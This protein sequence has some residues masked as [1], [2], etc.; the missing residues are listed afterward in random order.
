MNAVPASN[1]TLFAFAPSGESP[2]PASLLVPVPEDAPEA[3]ALF[4]RQ[5]AECLVAEMPADFSSDT[6]EEPVAADAESTAQPEAPAQPEAAAAATLSL[7]WQAI[8]PPPPP[9]VTPPPAE[10][11][12]ETPAPAIDPASL[13][14]TL[15]HEYPKARAPRETSVAVHATNPPPDDRAPVPQ[16]QTK[17][18]P[19]RSPALSSEPSASLQPEAS[20]A[21]ARLERAPVPSVPSV[22]SVPLAPP[23]KPAPAPEPVDSPEPFDSAEPAPARM[24]LPTPASR[25][26]PPVVP[27]AD[28]IGNAVPLSPTADLPPTGHP[29]ESPEASPSDGRF[30]MPPAPVLQELPV[31]SGP[32]TIETHSPGRNLPPTPS[33]SAETTLPFA[34]VAPPPGNRPATVAPN[35]TKPIESQT[36]PNYP[37]TPI[38]TDT[39][40]GTPSANHLA[41]SARKT[42]AEFEPERKSVRPHLDSAITLAP[43]ASPEPLPELHAPT[44]VAAADPSVR[45]ESVEKLQALL[46]REVRLFRQSEAESLQVVVEPASDLR[47]L[48]RVEL[49]DGRV[50]AELRCEQGDTVWLESHWPELQA[51]LSHQGVEL[52]DWADTTRAPRDSFA[53]TGSQSGQQRRSPESEFEPRPEMADAREPRAPART[54]VRTGRGL[55]ELWA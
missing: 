43:T 29:A 35:S 1:S 41:M 37:A 51:T 24:T 7:A 55:L 19:V 45:V 22:S 42:Y 52:R 40:S 48:L 46:V 44:K 49:R 54:P 30:K 27:P 15:V 13:R 28:K 3:A 16:T 47:L 23:A 18:K 32:K 36:V 17:P 20:P 11:P 34:H 31:V 8:F 38:P 6:D 26:T 4:A 10:T 12:A 33:T 25:P 39:S 2:A 9:P 21:P 53:G 50:E 5:L 14:E